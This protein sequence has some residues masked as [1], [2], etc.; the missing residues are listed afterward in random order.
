MYERF[1]E[2]LSN[3]K[4]KNKFIVK[5]GFYLSTLFGLENRLIEESKIID[6]D[7]LISDK[8]EFDYVNSILNK[9]RLESLDFLTNSLLWDRR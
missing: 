9:K 1:L 4:Y 6:T 3:S 5:G 8:I 7:N 2:R